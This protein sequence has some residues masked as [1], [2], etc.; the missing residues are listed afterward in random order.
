MTQITV[1]PE[2]IPDATENAFTGRVIIGIGNPR[3]APYTEL[4]IEL[5]TAK[6][7]WGNL[8]RALEEVECQHSRE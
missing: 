5:E 2:S 8:G 4:T 1:Y 7:L 6:H 3:S